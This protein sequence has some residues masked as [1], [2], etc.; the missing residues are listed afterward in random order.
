MKAA[1]AHGYGLKKWAHGHGLQGEKMPGVVS[2]MGKRLDPEGCEFYES[3]EWLLE[4]EGSRIFFL[5]GCV[6]SPFSTLLFR[7]LEF[8]FLF[9]P[10]VPLSRLGIACL[11]R[12]RVFFSFVALFAF[13]GVYCFAHYFPYVV[14]GCYLICMHCAL[15]LFL[16]SLHFC[17][18][19][20]FLGYRA[21]FVP[22]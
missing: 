10:S 1:H 16:F 20:T 3:I 22:D 19:F 15:S 13:L 2:Q 6:L 7:F 8:G 21:R 12:L 18:R 17:V 5:V 9:I 11:S 14:A 4:N